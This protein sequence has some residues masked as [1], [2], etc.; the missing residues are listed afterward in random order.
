MINTYKV[1]AK[2]TSTRATDYVNNFN[3]ISPYPTYII[4]DSNKKLTN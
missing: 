2:L 1:F 3:C 4:Y